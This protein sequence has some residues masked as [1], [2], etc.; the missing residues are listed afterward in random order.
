[1]G[2]V[3]AGA[4]IQTPYRRY[5]APARF[6]V[7][8]QRLLLLVML[9]PVFLLSL[10][11]HEWAHAWV[12]SRRGDPTA[13]M[14]GRLSLWPW[15]HWDLFGTILLPSACFLSNLPAF[16]WAKPVPVDARYFR[17]PRIDMALVAAAGPFSN[18]I[19]AGLGALL[20]S[21]LH[22]APWLET[23]PLWVSS[24]VSLAE[25]ALIVTMQA[26]LALAFFN[27]LPLPPLDG[28]VILQSAL[29]V[30][31]IVALQRATPFSIAAVMLLWVFGGLSFLTVP[32]RWS[33]DRLIEWAVL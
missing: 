10:C 15:K 11:V 23:L 17:N 21:T 19:L 32:V 30:R 3:A 14:A 27:L 2:R 24:A 29:P 16:G 7:M 5:G 1:M 6:A 25:V 4:Y 9:M 31:A 18:F 12:A 8:A 20:L 33:F 22:P 28:F 26:N 13:K